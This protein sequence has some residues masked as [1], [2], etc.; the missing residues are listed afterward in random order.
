MQFLSIFPDITKIAVR[1]ADDIRNQGV[2]HMIYIVFE[3][4]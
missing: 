2:C 1:T 3:F 4:S